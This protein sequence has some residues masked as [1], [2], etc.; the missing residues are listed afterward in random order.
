MCKGPE[1]GR[2]KVCFGKG[3]P[4][5][6]VPAGSVPFLVPGVHRAKIPACLA[7]KSCHRQQRREQSEC[8]HFPVSILGYAGGT[9]N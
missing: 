3:I 1:A 6:P 4:N 9:S 7:T 5:I 8:Q 2:R